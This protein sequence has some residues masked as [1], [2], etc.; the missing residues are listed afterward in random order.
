[1]WTKLSLPRPIIYEKVRLG[2]IAAPQE[3]TR[4][5][6]RIKRKLIFHENVHRSTK[7][8]CCEEEWKGCVAF[9][10]AQTWEKCEVLLADN[11]TAKQADLC[12]LDLTPLPGAADASRP[13]LCHADM[14]SDQTDARSS[15]AA[16]LSGPPTLLW[17]ACWCFVRPTALHHPCFLEEA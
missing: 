1:M 10:A 15:L 4:S 6:C 9:S 3:L 5:W 12:Q 13:A 11:S 16:L 2:Y 17:A 8:T 14:L 7:Y